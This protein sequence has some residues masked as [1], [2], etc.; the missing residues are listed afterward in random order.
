[1]GSLDRMA[2][3]RI[4]TRT[5]HMAVLPKHSIP[6]SELTN[7]THESSNTSSADDWT[8]KHTVAN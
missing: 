2:R 1:M 5:Q 6:F 7:R 4:S 3:D 8:P